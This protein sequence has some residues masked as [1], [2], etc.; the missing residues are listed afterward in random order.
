MLPSRSRNYAFTDNTNDTAFWDAVDCKYVVY[1]KE[2]AP[3]TGQPHLQG[4]I[5]FEHA[6][7]VSAVRQLFPQAHWEICRSVH[8]S[9][10]YCKKEGDFTERG[11]P[12]SQGKRTDFHD[13]YDSIREDNATYED[14]LELNPRIAIQYTQGFKS[15]I[16]IQVKHRSQDVV[17]EVHWF[18]GPTASG[19]S[20]Q[21]FLEA[22]ENAYV[23]PTTGR[24][25]DLYSGETE[26]I[27][28]D[29]R[30][31]QIDFALLLK[32]LDR[33]RMSVEVKGSS[34]KLAA[35]KFWITT[36]LDPVN[37]YTK[38]NHNTG[39]D[40]INENINQLVRRCTDIRRFG[41][42]PEYPIFINEQV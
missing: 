17:P 27:F 39:Q 14:I 41:P 32:I 23:V 35:T 2:V 34:V 18:Y 24:F 26:V 8:A 3:T 5:V 10:K 37:T 21:A 15:A 36:P 40:Y 6:K 33:Y 12:P 20:R 30:V 29:F 38:H 31:G 19:K 9:I 16:N 11:S 4:T 42:L 7:S 25:W 28:D 1:G 13:V 22:G